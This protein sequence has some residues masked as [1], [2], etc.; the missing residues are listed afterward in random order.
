MSDFY[1]QSSSIK[2]IYKHLNAA[3]AAAAVEYS[4]V[5]KTVHTLKT[6][7][8][9]ADHTH[10]TVVA[11]AGLD[12]VALV[13]VGLDRGALRLLAGHYCHAK[14]YSSRNSGQIRG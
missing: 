6:D 9:I 14:E 11:V 10:P 13:M 2:Q 8:G 12:N 5:T 3:A 7:S 1:L 4:V